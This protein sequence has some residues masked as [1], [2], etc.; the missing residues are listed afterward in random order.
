[1]M[2]FYIKTNTQSTARCVGCG[3]CDCRLDNLGIAIVIQ[4]NC[5]NLKLSAE[6]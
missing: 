3:K 5:K 6:S 4:T 1:M 2:L